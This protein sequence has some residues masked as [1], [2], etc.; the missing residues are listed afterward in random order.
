MPRPSRWLLVALGA[1]AAP[2]TGAAQVGTTTDIITGTVTG[3]DN[4]PLPGA[5][6]QATSLETQVSRQRTTDARGR[7]TILFPDGGGQYQLVVRYLGL[8]AARVAI[9]RQADEDRLVANV[10]MEVAAVSLDAVTVRARAPQRGVERPTPGST[11]RNLAPEVIARLPIDASDLNT[12]A[13]L[14]PGVVGIGETDSTSAAFSVAGQRSTANNITLDGLSFGSG[15]VPQDALRT[16]RVVTSTYD[17]ARGQFSGGLVA[18][19]TRSGTNVPQGSFTYGLRDR[20]LAWGGVTESPFDQGYTQNQ[21]SG[22]M[23]GPIVPNRLFVFGS[24]QGRW[25][26]QALPS[27]V[28]ADPPSLE[29]LGVSPD[30]AAR[31]LALAGATGVPMTV[32][33][34][35]GDRATDNSVALLR[36]DWN[37]SDA[38]TV[39]LRLDGRW[40]SQ[41]PTRVS[42][43]ALPATGGTRAQR[44]GGAMASLSSHFGEGFINE[45]RGYVSTDRSDATGFLE[46][47]EGRVQVGSS[48]SGTGLGRGIATLA[49]GGNPGFPQRT[50]ASTAEVTEELS[51]LSAAAGHRLKLGL[52]LNGA[53]QRAMQA[54]NQYGTFVFQSLD[55]LAAGQPAQFTRTLA[56]LE[57]AG[58]AWNGAL[59]LGDI[60]RAGGGVQLTYGARLEAARFTGAPAYN[61]AL[62][63]LFG[64]RT[65]RI[66]SELHASP[67]IGFT[68]TLG[69][70]GNGAGMFG[71]PPGTIVRGGVGDFRSLTPSAL[72][73]AALAAPGL[74]NA[75]AQLVC[76]GAAVPT[77]DWTQY[78]QDPA[79]IPSQCVDTATTVTITPHPNAT[80]FDPE[81]T[82]PHAWRASLGVQRRV[83]GTYTV[84]VDASYARGRS[85]YG[86][87]D[88]NLV[89]TPRFTLPDEANR[90]VFVPA[91]SIVPATGVL[92]LQQSRVNPRY[93]QVIAIGSDLQSDSRQLTLGLGGFTARGATFQLT[94]T[95]THARDQSSFSCCAASQG[96]SAP[97]TAGDPNARE[98]ATSS[99][100]RRHSLLGTVTYP[101]TAALEVTAIGRLTSGVPFTPL[102]GSD[103]NGDGARNDRALVFDP[104][105][106]ADTAL[107]NGMRALLGT[108]SP[109]VRAC[110]QSQAGR[111]AA[112]NSCTGPW[113][114]SLDLQVNW[115]P[116]YFGLD[117]RLTVS[118]LTVNLLGG[119]D[120]WLHGAANLHGWGFTAAPDA[121]LLYV[122]GF[123][124]AGPQYRY[125][126]NGR[127][128][129]T[130]GANG[131]VIVPFQVALQVHVTVGPDR[132]RDRLRAAFGGRRGGGGGGEGGRGGS[133]GA[134]G[135]GPQDFAARLARILP[136][137]IS[138]ILELRDS[139]A[140]LPDQVA[141]LQAIADSL[142]A[143]NRPVS[144]SLQAAVERAGERPD[145]GTLFARLRPKLAEGREHIRRAL[146]RARGVL[147]PDQWAKLPDALK[148]VGGRAGRGGR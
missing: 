17:V 47:P 132:T 124:P 143:Q 114:P 32:P 16:T 133:P 145:P 102:V 18:S 61:P 138:A 86:F 24:L 99:L 111:V 116:G 120:E 85:Q 35:P 74:S 90:P 144:D 41:D 64:I 93:G 95:L 13:T 4:Q 56:P 53:R 70:G 50:D 100:E 57:Q 140:L 87:R 96:F 125:A 92:S 49:F 54:P 20:D 7:F 104:A 88:L 25:R 12:L 94:Y 71:E 11:E 135:G 98:W 58:T 89:G 19:T 67:R 59:Y 113:Q 147:T 148:T 63:S 146:G 121:V 43:L 76:V 127:F 75:E 1:L 69:G 42:P 126:V 115:R 38:Q 79:T 108:A 82:A 21:L 55:A 119:L 44:A 6:V 139:L 122:R 91:D 110:L 2:L 141:A 118:L 62:D 29:R 130:A 10:Q 80:V 129:A 23:G 9:A 34:L 65:D 48:L 45:V 28:S 84:S 134:E 51:W 117:R 68:W 37:L 131:G 30:S 78:A 3:P 5:V 112:R 73:S 39:M 137:P 60:W 14:A 136:N 22:G 97:T 8:A 72:Y 46:L 33:A 109:G 77:P 52:Y 83:R 15:N 123:D 26:G 31:F 27:L 66:P 40:S 128:G 101:I 36:L 81:Y 107:A 142:D 105:T 103:V 106:T